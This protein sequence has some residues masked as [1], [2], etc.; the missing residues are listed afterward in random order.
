VSIFVTSPCNRNGNP[1]VIDC[2]CNW[3]F[4]PDDPESIREHADQHAEFVRVVTWRRHIPASFQEREDMKSSGRAAR[5]NGPTFLDRVAGAELELRALYERSYE[6]AIGRGFGISH[7]TLGEYTRLAAD[8]DML[9]DVNIS[10]ELRQR[11]GNVNV[12]SGR[13]MATYWEP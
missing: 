4:V 8:V 9:G 5:R 11:Y 6:A 1:T 12:P 2:W 10:R 3:P 13:I 7:P